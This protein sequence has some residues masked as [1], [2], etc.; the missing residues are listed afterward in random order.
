MNV[1]HNFLLG[2]KVQHSGQ[3]KNGL[4]QRIKLKSKYTYYTVH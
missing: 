3:R 1:A 2:K 4:K